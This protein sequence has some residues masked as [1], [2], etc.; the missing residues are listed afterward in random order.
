M[1]VE[2]SISVLLKT[3]SHNDDEPWTISGTKNVSKT[4]VEINGTFQLICNLM[5][6]E[7]P[8]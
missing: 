3:F 8:H 6:V 1:K 2:T 4:V 5:N 7:G